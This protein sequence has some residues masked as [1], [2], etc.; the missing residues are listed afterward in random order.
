MCKVGKLKFLSELLTNSKLFPNLC[1]KERITSR[2]Q[3]VKGVQEEEEE[4]EEEAGSI[5]SVGRLEEKVE[6]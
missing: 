3:K 4:E 5:C 6:G 2:G 1:R